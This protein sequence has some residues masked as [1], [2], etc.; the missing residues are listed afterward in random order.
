MTEASGADRKRAAVKV[1]RQQ[2]H[3]SVLQPTFAAVRDS[4]SRTNGHERAPSGGG[5]LQSHNARSPNPTAEAK[6]FPESR[7]AQ[8][9]S[10]IPSDTALDMLGGRRE[11]K[12]NARSG[13]V[14]RKPSKAIQLTS[15]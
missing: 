14:M 2:E 9:F 1:G 8:D 10:R 5:S 4:G 11:A 15:T 13:W 7:F 6:A 3:I 12:A